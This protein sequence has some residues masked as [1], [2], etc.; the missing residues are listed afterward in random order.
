MKALWEFSDF[1]DLTT[2]LKWREQL[3]LN[4]EFYLRMEIEFD[5]WRT[6]PHYNLIDLFENIFKYQFVYPWITASDWQPNFDGIRSQGK[7]L[8]LF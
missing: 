3:V 5:K 8:F 2:V 6:P 1:L 7:K 4:T